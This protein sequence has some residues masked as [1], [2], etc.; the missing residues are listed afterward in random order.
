MTMRGIALLIAAMIL[1]ISPSV[2]A[3]GSQRSEREIYDEGYEWLDGKPEERPDSSWSTVG[4][5]IRD[6]LLEEQQG[7]ESRA[8]DWWIYEEMPDAE[9][10]EQSRILKEQ[11]EKKRADKQ[12]RRNR[13]KSYRFK[14]IMEDDGYRYYL[15]KL[16]SRWVRVPYTAEEFMADVWLRLVPIEKEK[17]QE[18]PISE[19]EQRM[20]RYM[21]EQIEQERR[22][23]EAQKPK[24]TP[25]TRPSHYFLAHYYLRPT[26]RQLQF[27]SELEVFNRPDN[28]IEEPPYRPNAWE[29]LVPHS[30]ESDMYYKVLKIMRSSPQNPKITDMK[31]T[32]ALEKFFRISL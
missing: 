12:N 1:G 20:P 10:A 19:E 24:I 18:E 26:R 32:D 28:N 15:D 4:S 29:N 5:K 30:V 27:I 23:K 25:D 11:E 22:A 9:Q 13:S 14:L 16:Q 3:E 8:D 6:V 31:F 7:D 2:N 17:A 21:R